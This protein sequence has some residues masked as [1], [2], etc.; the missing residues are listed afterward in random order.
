MK[1]IIIALFV[2]MVMGASAQDTIYLN[3]T[4]KVNFNLGKTVKL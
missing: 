4:T 3:G 2:L 1:K